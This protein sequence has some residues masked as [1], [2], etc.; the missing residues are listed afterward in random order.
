MEF[1]FYITLCVTKIH[2]IVV[3]P[4][5]ACKQSLFE[6]KML[7]GIFG[8]KMEEATGARRNCIMRKFMIF[9]PPPNIIR[10]MK[11]RGMRFAG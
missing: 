3:I 11:L 5:C 8:P 10:A 1:M 2:F 9:T 4:F 6:N 7:R